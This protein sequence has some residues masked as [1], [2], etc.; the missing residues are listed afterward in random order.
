M[1]RLRYEIE[2]FLFVCRHGLVGDLA[3]ESLNPF[4]LSETIMVLIPEVFQKRPFVFLIGLRLMG[5]EAIYPK[6]K[7]L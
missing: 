5:L 4:I 1:I 3:A 2:H 7:L 6:L